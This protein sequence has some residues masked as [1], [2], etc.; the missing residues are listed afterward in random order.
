MPMSLQWYRFFQDLIT[1]IGGDGFDK[2]T[3]NYNNIGTKADSDLAVTAGNGLTGGGNL[4]ASFT[5]ALK[6]DT[7]WTAGTGTANK[8]AFATYGGQTMGVI[9]SQA[10]AQANDDAVKANAQRILAIEAALRSIG[11]ID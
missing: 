1:R 7:G 3:D 6:Q 2:V 8:G 5:I 9:Y 11:A 4:M 10:V